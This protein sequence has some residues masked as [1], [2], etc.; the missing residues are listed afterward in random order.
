MLCKNRFFALA[1]GLGRLVTVGVL[2]WGVS[3]LMGCCA[4]SHAADAPW[5]HGAY[6]QDGSEWVYEWVLDE[7]VDGNGAPYKISQGGFGPTR[8]AAYQNSLAYACENLASA[9]WRR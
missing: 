2:A 7:G 9:R 5:N 6:R 4:A 1:K 8:E 3:F